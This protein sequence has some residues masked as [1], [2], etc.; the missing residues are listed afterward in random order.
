[1]EIITFSSKANGV[2]NTIVEAGH[3]IVSPFIDIANGAS[4]LIGMFV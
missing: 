4:Q 2:A 3:D 1:M